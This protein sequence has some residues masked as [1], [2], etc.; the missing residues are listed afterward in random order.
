MRNLFRKNACISGK[1]RHAYSAAPTAKF[2]AC[3]IPAEKTTGTETRG[4]NSP[5]AI[6][7]PVADFDS[8][9]VVFSLWSDVHP[10]AGSFTTA[11]TD[12]STLVTFGFSFLDV[13][14]ETSAVY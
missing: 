14:R 8:D 11:G 9:R 6:R 1:A 5:V 10:L 3:K 7:N 12:T 2:S 13:S 4:R